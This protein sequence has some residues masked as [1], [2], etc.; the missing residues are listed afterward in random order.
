[1][2]ALGT[3]RTRPYPLG[4]ILAVGALTDTANILQDGSTPIGQLFA[5]EGGKIETQRGARPTRI[6]RTVLVTEGPLAPGP[7]SP[8][9]AGACPTIPT[10]AGPG[11]GHGLKDRIGRARQG[12]AGRRTDTQ[13]NLGDTA[14]AAPLD[15]SRGRRLPGRPPSSA[16][17][18][19]RL[20]TL[21]CSLGQAAGTFSDGSRFRVSLGAS[22]DGRLAGHKKSAASST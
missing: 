14:G 5:L 22:Q 16:V 20:G 8:P 10:P 4:G 13:N 11:Q 15:C 3:S 1:M 9:S 6:G 18:I 2:V 21:H 19:G 7:G 17:G 12:T